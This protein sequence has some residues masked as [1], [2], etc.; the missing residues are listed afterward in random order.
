MSTI[1]EGEQVELFDHWEYVKNIKKLLK[2]H[3]D[4]LNTVSF[5][6]F[7]DSVT[8]LW[9]DLALPAFLMSYE[10]IAPNYSMGLP[11][12]KFED[13]TFYMPATVK[14]V[15]DSYITAIS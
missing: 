5:C 14:F 4:E 9:H 10:S 7:D 1:L 3:F 11:A 6:P 8:T 12:R 13:G 15:G 2:E